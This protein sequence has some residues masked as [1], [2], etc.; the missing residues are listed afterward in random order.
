MKRRISLIIVAILIMS[1]MCLMGCGKYTS[2]YKATMLVTTNDSRSASMS[3]STFN[4][5]KVLKL[6]SG[7][8][9]TS[10]RFYG[11][12]EKGNVEVYCDYGQVLRQVLVMEDDTEFDASLAVPANS[13]IYILIESKGEAK[14][15]KFEFEIE[16]NEESEE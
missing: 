4:G 1:T 7:D 11:K 6:K 2:N 12:L 13:T 5:T 10:V 15:G 14:E 16:D 3:F 8:K 9:D